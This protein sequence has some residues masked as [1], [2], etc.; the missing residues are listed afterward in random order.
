MEDNQE[1]TSKDNSE[2]HE[3][4]DEKIEH[5]SSFYDNEIYKDKVEELDKNLE[6]LADKTAE[7]I[8]N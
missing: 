8:F 3:T 7:R 4:I 1:Y 5:Y 2:K 6:D